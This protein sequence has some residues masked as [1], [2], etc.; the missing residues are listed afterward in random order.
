MRYFSL[1]NNSGETLDI[2]THKV[3]FNEV[4]GLGYEEE[5][6]FRRVGEVWWLNTASYRQQPIKGKILFNSYDG[7]EPYTEFRNFVKFI[8]KVPLTLLYYPN[9]LGGKEYRKKIRVT[10]LEKSEINEYGVLEEPIEFMPYTPWYE[11]YT[12][13][14]RVGEA[15]DGAWIWGDGDTHPDVAFPEAPEGTIPTRFGSEESRWVSLKVESDVESPS[16][17]VIYGPLSNP[18]WTHYVDG[19]VVETGE[20]TSDETISIEDDEALVIDNTDEIGQI[21]VY[22]TYTD[23]EG[24]TQLGEPLR[25][26]YP[27]RNFNTKCFVTLR[28]GLNRIA[29]SS[30]NTGSVRLMLE[31]HIYNATV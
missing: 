20:F 25:D 11:I 16:K 27:K 22:S 5:T 15:F 21:K 9:G 31:G 18:I 7:V 12:V 23:L 29:L 19:K 26:L 28:A 30:V 14:N 17:L 1:I 8:Q 24:Q 3:F 6:S 13:K 4:S 2:T 10:K